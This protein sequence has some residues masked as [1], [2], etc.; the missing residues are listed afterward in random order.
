VR[1]GALA[2][3][4][5][6]AFADASV[7]QGSAADDL[8]AAG[9][10]L[11][12]EGRNDSGEAVSAV[13]QG[14]VPVIGTQVTCQSCHG[15]SGMGAIESGRVPSVL[16]GPLLFAPDAQRRR[17]G[18]TETSL[19]QALREGIDPA[20]QALDPLMP[21]FRLG[22]RDVA[23]LA[24]Y[25]RQL[26]AAPAPGVG[27][28]SVRLAT[29][30]AGAVPPDEERAMLDVL[31]AFV[32]DRNR[33]GPQRLRGGHAP[34]QAKETFRAWELDV[35]RLGGPSTTWRTQLA[36]RYRERPA[37]AVVSGLAAEG[38]QP[39]HDFCEA[40]EVACLLPNADQ[41]PS[42][43]RGFYSLYFSEGLGLEA[44]ILA[45]ELLA[46]G[47]GADVLQMASGSAPGAADAAERL[48][49]ALERRGGHARTEFVPD[50]PAG[51]AALS[52]AISTPASAVVVWVG[53]N[54]VRRL[55]AA[56]GSEP[57]LHFSSTL[58]EADWN[59]VPAALRGRSQLAHLLRLPGAPDPPRERFRAWA[60]GRGVSRRHERVQAQT[61]FACLATAES[62]KHVGRYPSREYLMDLLDHASNLAAYLPLYPR[63]GFGPGQR[64][65][66][67][68]GYL[69]DLSGR[70]GPAWVVPS[71]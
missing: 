6:I 37:F 15:R 20:G 47:R 54:A 23:A 43:T 52:R 33:S 63:P 32:A 65:L 35:W 14:D 21:R 50:E 10:R 71:P 49:R 62:I 29:V 17:P 16:A 56:G 51:D 42:G 40:E 5:A 11:Y 66:N 22:D 24:A 60:A 2:V 69:V 39:I 12:R 3:I 9:Q 19:A 46:S 70:R 26:G 7:S 38:W 34:G 30:V 1:A 58:L 27:P 28:T 55:E 41:A 57:P 44:E 48:G 64:V 25:L 18:Y 31:E 68:G 61:F 67:R 4:L 53:R 8:V 45:S 36:A 59:A 13:V